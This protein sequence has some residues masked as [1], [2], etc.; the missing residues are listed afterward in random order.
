MRKH[1]AFIGMAQRCKTCVMQS[2]GRPSQMHVAS[3]PAPSGLSDQGSLH[4]D[5]RAMPMRPSWGFLY[6]SRYSLTTT[7]CAINRLCPQRHLPTSP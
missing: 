5:Q 1:A 4:S 7:A 2:A 6:V 3:S